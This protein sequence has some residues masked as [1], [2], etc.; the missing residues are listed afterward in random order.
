MERLG[1]IKLRIAAGAGAAIALAVGLAYMRVP[2][3]YRPDPPFTAAL[4]QFRLMP[5]GISGTPPEAYFAA[6]KPYEKTAFDLS[7]GKRLYSWF[8]CAACH[9][10]EGT[11][12]KGPSFVDG[13]WLYGPSM[14]SIVGS[15][16]DGRPHGMPA[17]KSRMTSDE[18]WQ[19]AG[20]IKALGAYSASVNAPGRNDDKLGR[21]AENRAPAAIVFDQGPTPMHPDQG[22]TP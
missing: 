14:A 4:D 7:Q 8:G 2:R 18:I 6:G 9:G 19:L 13:W 12:G 20:Y 3:Q 10:A 21:P 15:I 11:G 16:R 22:P 1:S 17:F 5:N